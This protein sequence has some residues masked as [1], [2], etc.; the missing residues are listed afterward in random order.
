MKKIFVLLFCLFFAQLHADS[1]IVI[2][3]SKQ[4][5][6]IVIGK[7]SPSGAARGTKM[8]VDY[9]NNKDAENPATF[10]ANIQSTS[11][12]WEAISGLRLSEYKIT[13]SGNK[14]VGKTGW[15]MYFLDE[16][17]CYGYGQYV[18]TWIGANDKNGLVRANCLKQP[19]EI[20][21]AYRV[22]KKNDPQGR[23]TGILKCRVEKNLS[24]DLS[25]C[26]KQDW[27][28]WAKDSY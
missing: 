6:Y 8:P 11:T 19:K 23:T 1:D 16:F 9:D 20:K 25:K 14:A 10:R 3:V 22:A 12:D 26:D 24:I 27:S 4:G 15:E 5:D 21:L 7:D 17:P 13:F 28:D 18:R 2:D